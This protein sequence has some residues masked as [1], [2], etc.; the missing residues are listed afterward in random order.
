MII[1]VAGGALYDVADNFISLFYNLE[2]ADT[3]S[4]VTV[5]LIMR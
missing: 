1:R 4:K 2:V 3:V 5:C